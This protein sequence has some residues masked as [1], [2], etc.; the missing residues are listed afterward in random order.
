MGQKYDPSKVFKLYLPEMEKECNRKDLGEDYRYDSD[1]E[2]EIDDT[3][4][5]EEE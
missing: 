1:D 5:N 4:D 3:D 2:N